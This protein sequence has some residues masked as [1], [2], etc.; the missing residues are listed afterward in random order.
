[1]PSRRAW[2][3]TCAASAGGLL[4]GGC[5]CS[6]Q[7]GDGAASNV[8]GPD[9][10]SLPL[11]YADHNL[12][13]IS[14]DA[15]QAAHV[16]ALGYKR[17]TTPQLDAF[18]AQS[19]LFQGHHSVAS[20]TVPASMSWFTGVYPSEHRIKN[21][22]T[23]YTEKEQRPAR[24]K[25]LSP[26]LVT[27]AQVLKQH[28]YETGGYT[29]N[30]GVSGAFGFDQGFDTYHHEKQEFGSLANSIPESLKWIKARKNKKF[31][32]FLH[33]YDVH[34]QFAPPGGYDFRF[35]DRSY[36][37]KYTGSQRE[38]ELLREE[39][40]ENGSVELRESDVRFWRAIYD[41]KIQRADERFGEFLKAYSRL[42][43]LKKTLFVITSDH[44][45]E[46]YEH[47]RFDHGFTLYAEQL[48]VPLVIRLPGQSR[49]M[50]VAAR[51]SSI[52]VMP[53]I[54]ELLDVPLTDPLQTQLRGESLVTA[55]QDNYQPRDLFAETDYREYTF[56]R[57]IISPAGQKLIFTLES[58]RRELYDLN[59]DAAEQQDLSAVNVESADELQARLFAHF[60]NI[61]H[62]LT[63]QRWQ[64]GLNPV[65]DSQ[66]K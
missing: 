35:V 45:T 40:L 13:F 46:F 61:G 37:G 16:S 26:H 11:K 39:G 49:G 44:G 28:G 66:A 3:A 55:L 14:F 64:P 42:D 34:G 50:K 5:S 17:A 2:L 12:V 20:W 63:A 27:L 23:I 47:R 6:S 1:M 18:A 22:F 57:A 15:L 48:H 33:G 59:A 7:P 8:S 4:V 38:Q 65:Y 32:L 60:R 56:Q 52:D 29:G 58:G 62:D 41:E 43:L 19:F 21:K 36:D 31:F 10:R 51:T 54:L 9:P 24:L 25:E 53:T 30:A